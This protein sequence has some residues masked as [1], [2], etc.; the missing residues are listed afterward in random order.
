MKSL[1][2]ETILSFDDVSNGGRLV[3]VSLDWNGSPLLLFEIGRPPFPFTSGDASA[4][5]YAT[6]PTA[7]RVVYFDQQQTKAID[8][9]NLTSAKLV[10][11]V[12]RID[13]DWLLV[14]SSGGMAYRY[15]QDG[16]HLQS[17]TLGDAINDV[18]TTSDG[19]IWVSYF[20]EGVFG[21]GICSNGL[22]CFDSSGTDQFRFSE[23]ANQNGLPPIDDCYALNVGDDVWLSYYSDFPLVKISDFTLR[24]SW[25]GLGSFSAFAVRNNSIIALPSYRKNHLV[26]I[27]LDTR[28]VQELKPLDES[29]TLLADFKG[30]LYNERFA[31]AD[32]ETMTYYKPFNARSRGYEFFIYTEQALFRVP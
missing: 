6:V 18:Q 13:E 30:S 23:F 28:R 25:K 24:Q 31:N 3:Q 19:R 22:V 14:E 2:L 20:D 10:S 1:P 4:H 21:S 27:D 9:P 15:S 8:L 5:W 7:Y 17:L 29:G 32:A 26:E 11:F 12:Q 16:V